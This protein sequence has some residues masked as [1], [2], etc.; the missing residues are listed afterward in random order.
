MQLTKRFSIL[1]S[2]I[3]L[4]LA[5]GSR[6][7]LA[8]PRTLPIEPGI[9]VFTLSDDSRRQL[10]LDLSHVLTVSLDM[11]P[12]WYTYAN[13]PGGMG[14]PTILSGTTG[15][16][17]PLVSLYPIGKAKPDAFDPSVII[18]AYE[19]G[20]LLFS[21]VPAASTEPFPVVMQLELLLCHPTKCVP[22]RRNLSHD[23]PE[24][25]PFP[26]AEDQ[27]W[28]PTFRTLAESGSAAN[29][30]LPA[31]PENDDAETLVQWSFSP[32]YLQP[33]LEV[34]S[35][36]S[37]ILMGLLAGLI[38]NIM[39]CVLPVVS[40][41]LSALLNSSSI[42]TEAER[43]RAFREH[44][45]FFALGVITFFMVLAAALGVTGQAWGALFQNRWLVL[46]AAGLILAL[47]LSLFGLY[48]LPV[49]DLKFGIKSRSPRI[50]A[51][52]TGN[53][54][55]LLAT[56]CSGP[57]L[58]GVLGWSL[59][60]GGGVIFAVFAS[61]G[62]GMAFP[63]LLLVANPR[64]SRFLPRSGPWIEYVEKGIAFFLVGTAVYLTGIALGDTVLRVLAP[65]WAMALGGW[66]WV[67]TRFAR[68]SARWALRTAS[69]A[70]VAAMIIWTGP[71]RVSESAWE[72]FDPVSLHKRI[73]QERIF[74][75]FT[76]DWCPTC[77]VLEATV[78][79]PQNVTR[80]K[81][82]H[83]IAFIKVD[84]T[85]R[86][87][88]GEALLRALGSMSIPAAALFPPGEAGM[89]PLVLRDLYTRS[90][91]ENIMGSWEK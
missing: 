76:A 5:A 21:G 40:L 14:K 57:F 6:P 85:G 4:I 13:V 17:L 80:W 75:S 46:T 62:L 77:K 30:A 23:G 16:T 71:D 29:S 58:G 51:F 31:T 27:P 78:L 67:R 50:Q 65:L 61:I 56:P 3:L 89:T 59:I 87:V 53:L 34:S 72:P 33:A 86:N 48:H 1:F 45:A 70:L 41:K 44:N 2:L 24:T 73:G 81:R 9:Q 35:L 84:L 43:I 32:T 79:T 8:A 47:S 26:A 19:S 69:L 42:D 63:Y 64:L 18:N 55:T 49:I 39:P 37:A 66:L 83:D 12:E 68:P 36:L 28:W 11:E 22:Y 7:S 91:L 15:D 54:A 10:G 20:T 82:G 88:E 52:F 38:L 60:Q 90:Q 25:G 74:I